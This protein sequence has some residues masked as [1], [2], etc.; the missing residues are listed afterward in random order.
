MMCCK[1]IS[2]LH[3]CGLVALEIKTYKNLLCGAF[4]PDIRKFAPTKISYYTV[5][6][7]GSSYQ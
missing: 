3:G 2:E 4:W 6:T 1:A 7:K 5:H